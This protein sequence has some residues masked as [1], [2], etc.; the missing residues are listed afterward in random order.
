MA[1]SFHNG[2][3]PNVTALLPPEIHLSIPLAYGFNKFSTIVK[4]SESKVI[5][6]LIL[7]EL[8][9]IFGGW[10]NHSNRSSGKQVS[11][12]DLPVI[13]FHI[14]IKSLECRFYVIGDSMVFLYFKILFCLSMLNILPQNHSMNTLKFSEL[15]FLLISFIIIDGPRLLLSALWELLFLTHTLN[16][17]HFTPNASCFDLGMFLISCLRC[18]TYIL[19]ILM[20]Q[21]FPKPTH[22]Q[23]PNFMS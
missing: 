12:I 23:P 13:V 8:P 17:L 11:W 1:L 16:F 3:A 10:F 22:S 5:S 2:R 4:V 9:D 14:C 6:N 19:I 15:T 18:F 20:S 21:L 7:R